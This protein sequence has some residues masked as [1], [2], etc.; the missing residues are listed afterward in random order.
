MKK[1]LA[2]LLLSSTM[3]FG[4]QC[5]QFYSGGKQIPVTNTTELCNSFYVVAYDRSVKGP[6]VS[7]ERFDG[8]QH[9]VSRVNTYRV[10]HRLV[11]GQRAELTDYPLSNYDRGHMTPADD[12]KQITEMRDT[13]LLSNMTPQSRKL[14]RGNWKNLEIHIR[15]KAV[16][17]TYVAT[18]VIYGKETL[19]PNKIGIP[20]QY[21]KVVWYSDHTTEAYF[22]DNKDSASIT[23]TS[24]DK[25]NS[26]SGISF[27]K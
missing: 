16:G 26:M 12:A 25:I 17:V 2:I 5:D 21:Y 14:N 23:R 10:D 8:S 13:F 27:P 18:G 19:G 6:K 9:A 24:I 11:P 7:F 3:V 4:G 22:A 20:I 1:L 15:S